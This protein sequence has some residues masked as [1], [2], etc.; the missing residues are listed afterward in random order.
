LGVGWASAGGWG[1]GEWGGPLLL[2]APHGRALGGSGM[3]CGGGTRVG[4]AGR[5]PKAA[6]APGRMMALAM[7]YR[8]RV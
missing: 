8:V 5:R 6:R 2:R 1:S 3:G 4:A 7:G